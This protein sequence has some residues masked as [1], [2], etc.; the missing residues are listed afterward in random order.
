MGRFGGGKEDEERR[1]K[2]RGIGK[3]RMS[4]GVGSRGERG[5]RTRIEEGRMRR[6]G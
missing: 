2:K 3:G 5:G 6:R 1:A 4:K